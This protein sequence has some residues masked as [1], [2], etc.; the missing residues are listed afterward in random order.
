[1]QIW[2]YTLVSVIAVSAVSL[3]GIFTLAMSGKFLNK[4]ILVLVSFAAGTLL[5]DALIHLLPEAYSSG[6]SLTPVYV[7][8]GII[9][10]FIL[11]KI[12]KWRHCHEA[13]CPEHSH[14]LPYVILIGDGLHN[15]IDG[16]I[17]AASFLVNVPV[18][19]ATTIAVI[20]HEIPQEIGDFGSLVYGGFSKKK[21]L[22]YNFLS[23]LMAVIGAIL[24]LILSSKVSGI[25]IFL[26]PFAA[27]GFIYIAA[28]DIIPELHRHKVQT[29][30][31]SLIQTCSI[32]AGVA[33]MY[34][35][36]FFE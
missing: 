16:M 5:G 8:S 32:V 26:A 24:V 10:F 31:S 17:I 14:V 12:I 20:F 7:L 35:L 11:E 15:F 27:G 4:I 25:E 18:G 34:S 22:I 6:N 30:K 3:F 21:A 28:A 13:G 9:F 2:L 23:A 29:L 36:L 19:I 33:I 1:M